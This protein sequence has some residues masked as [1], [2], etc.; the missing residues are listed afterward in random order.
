MLAL[1]I[2]GLISSSVSAGRRFVPAALSLAL[3]GCGGTPVSPESSLLP[4]TPGNYVLVGYAQPL[5]TCQ[6]TGAFQGVTLLS[7]ITLSRQGTAWLA[8]SATPADGDVE[9]WFEDEGFVVVDSRIGGDSQGH[10][11]RSQERG[12]SRRLFG[13]VLGSGRVGRGGPARGRL[14]ASDT[15]CIPLRLWSGHGRRCA[16]P[17]DLR[18]GVLSDS[19]PRSL[20][21]RSDAVLEEAWSPYGDEP[22][23][24]ATR[25]DTRCGHRARLVEL[26]DQALEPAC[27]IPLPHREL[28]S[29]T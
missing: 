8:R 9:L 28:G 1:A 25:S 18:T 12:F 4:L 5:S 17:R 10:R 14:D 15:E 22:G 3:A 20:R 13:G 26:D 19:K 7:Y 2:H 24:R 6:G 23:D 16:R 11:T 29:R 21:S 27:T